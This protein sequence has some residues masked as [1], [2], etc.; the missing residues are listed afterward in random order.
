MIDFAKR[1]GTFAAVVT[2]TAAL[3]VVPA[4]AQTSAPTAAPPSAAPAAPS[5][6]PA[7]P[8][9]APAKHAKPNPHTARLEAYIKSLHAKLH[10]TA[11]QQPQWDQVAQVMREN[12][13]T[14]DKLVHERTS[15]IRTMTAVE[16]LQTYSEFVQA[17]ADGL[18]KLASAFDGL[19]QSMSDA[20]KKNAD[21][22]FRSIAERHIRHNAAK[23]AKPAAP[24]QK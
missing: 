19:Y 2:L 8:S 7:A 17:H 18:K 21:A 11:A 1:Q 6:P 13:E 14:I 22:V 9:A 4:L 15:K 23:T 16:N 3:L 5:T 24:A 12:A 10:I 20:Q